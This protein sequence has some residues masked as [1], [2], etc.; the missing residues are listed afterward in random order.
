MLQWQN[1]TVV[2]VTVTGK[3]VNSK[4]KFQYNRNWT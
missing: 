1:Y 2:T 3:Y 4:L